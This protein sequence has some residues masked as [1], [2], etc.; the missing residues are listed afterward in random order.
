VELAKR[1]PWAVSLDYIRYHGTEW[2]YCDCCRSAFEEYSGEKVDD[3]PRDVAAGR[4]LNGKWEDFRRR[5]I[6]EL[7]REVAKRVRA[8]APGVKIR[9]DVFCKAKGNAMPVAQEWDR[10]CRERLLDMIC[11]MNGMGGAATLDELS[12]LIR[13]QIPA[14][15]GVPLVPTYYPSLAKRTGN[16][17]DFMDTVRVG[18]NAGLKGFCA[19]TFDGRLIEMLGLEKVAGRK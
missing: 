5:N 2:C 7:V 12:E 14:S 17:D 15:A 10:W 9:A 8:Q 3:W 6:T 18:R 1:G 19:F 16:A 11:P 13:A 4:R